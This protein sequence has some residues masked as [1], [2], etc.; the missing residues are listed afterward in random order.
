M[1]TS[2]NQQAKVPI[3]SGLGGLGGDGM[4]HKEEKREAIPWQNVPTH[5]GE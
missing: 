2:L 4:V 5:T 3:G 1:I